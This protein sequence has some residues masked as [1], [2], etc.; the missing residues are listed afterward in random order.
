MILCAGRWNK[1]TVCTLTPIN[2]ML[3]KIISHIS[4]VLGIWRLQA[5]GVKSLL[6]RQ[7]RIREVEK[8]T[9]RQTDLYAARCL[10]QLVVMRSCEVLWAD[11]YLILSAGLLIFIS[12]SQLWSIAQ[13]HKHTCTNTCT[14]SNTRKQ[15]R[16][17]ERKQIVPRDL[18][19]GLKWASLQLC[20]GVQM[21]IAFHGAKPE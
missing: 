2:L 10:A 14:K 21:L 20:R 19:M 5:A 7:E 18:R 1:C 9:N 4:G 8:Q 6:E 11:V 13:I 3:G 15:K 16:E 17:R 12:I